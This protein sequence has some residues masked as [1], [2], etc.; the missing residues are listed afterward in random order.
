M[1]KVNDQVCSLSAPIA[2]K[3]SKVYQFFVTLL[4]PL[5]M[6]SVTFIGSSDSWLSKAFWPALYLLGSLILSVIKFRINVERTVLLIIHYLHAIMLFQQVTSSFLLDSL[7]VFLCYSV[8]LR[9]RFTMMPIIWLYTFI[10]TDV[11]ILAVGLLWIIPE[12]DITLP[13][14]TVARLVLETIIFLLTLLITDIYADHMKQETI[15][16]LMVHNKDLEE[17]SKKNESRFVCMCQEIR[18]P[19]QSLLSSAELLDGCEDEAQR[20]KYTRIIKNGCHAVLATINNILD[21]SKIEENKMELNVVPSSLSETVGS[22]IEMLEG[23]ADS[24]G[25]E[26]SYLE[27]N[28]FPSSLKFDSHRLQQVVFNMASTSI[29]HTSQ[30]KVVISSSW[31]PL[32]ED[33]ADITTLVQDELSRSD[34]KNVLCPLS[35]VDDAKAEFKK[36]LKIGL[37]NLML[38]S[39]REEASCCITARKKQ[40]KKSRKLTID[41]LIRLGKSERARGVAAIISPKASV[42]TAPDYSLIN[43]SHGLIKIEVMSTGSGIPKPVLRKMLQQNNQFESDTLEGYSAFGLGLW[44]CRHIVKLMEGGVTIKSKVGLG[45]NAIIILPSEVCFDALN[46][47]NKNIFADIK[48]MKGKTCLIVDYVQEDS[49]VL[50]ELLQRNGLN[51]INQSQTKEAIKIY[52]ANKNIDIVIVYLNEADTNGENF[53]T[54]IRKYEAAN[55]LPQVPLLIL[56]DEEESTLLSRHKNA[57]S[58]LSQHGNNYQSL[59][60]PAKSKDIL[61]AAE[62]LLAIERIQSGDSSEERNERNILFVDDDTVIQTIMFNLL[63]HNGDRVTSCLSIAEGKKEIERGG[64]EYDLI[65]IDNELPDGIGPDLVEFYE[66]T[67]L[68]NNGHKK[69]AA[70]VS[71]GDISVEMQKEIYKGYSIANFIKKPISKK[72]IIDIVK[73]IY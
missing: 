45:T 7:I 68:T 23:Q 44:F 37:G 34:W 35:E 52:Q 73:S 8:I 15:N 18:N 31:I 62:K 55:S 51:T 38:P 2:T 6:L 5:M 56:T 46:T 11:I 12:R 70:V 59:Q 24:K 16:E 43:V 28:P 48:A 27:S 26:L 1:P 63:K 69:K 57:A 33:S 17:K 3:Y 4:L 50:Q 66:K 42:S 22:V 14:K 39:H 32:D 53:I 61:A 29:A 71:I 25:I 20:S 30:G 13:L 64:H 47:M 9:N 21:V 58:V 60:K 10:I 41:S 49:F 67:F 65:F 19:L 40:I 54:E 72:T 36:R